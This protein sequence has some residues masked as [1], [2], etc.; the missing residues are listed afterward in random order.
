MHFLEQLDFRK[1]FLVMLLQCLAMII[2]MFVGLF[3]HNTASCRAHYSS[4]KR[5]H[6]LNIRP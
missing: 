3:A 1:C 5:N 2:R 6:I 4:Q